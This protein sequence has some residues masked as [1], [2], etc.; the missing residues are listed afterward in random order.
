MFS[1]KKSI[2][3]VMLV[4][5]YLTFN[6]SDHTNAPQDRTPK[7][8]KGVQKE[9][10][11][12]DN[13]FGFK[14]FEKIVAVEQDKNVFISPLSVSMALGM[15]L[16]GANGTTREAM[17]ETLE[18][19]GLTQEEINNSYKNLMEFLYSLDPDVQFQLAN[20]IWYRLGY[21]FE[22]DFIDLNVNYF[23]AEVA[24]LDFSAADAATTMNQWVEAHTNGRIKDMIQ[25]PINPYTIMF[26]INAIYFKGMW[27]YQ[28][29]PKYTKEDV[30]I[31]PDG[32][33]TA[34]QMMAQR[35]RYRYMSN[36]DFQAIDLPYG[37]GDFCM[38]IFLPQHINAFVADFNQENYD[39]WITSFSAD[40]VTLFVPKF[41]LDYEIEL[42]DVLTAL[43]MGIA[44]SDRADFTK[45]YA[46]GN[47]YISKVKHK[48]FLEVNE[49][50]TEA[51]AAT[52]VEMTLTSAPEDPIIVMDVNR[53]FVFVIR[54]TKS[55][56]ILFVG[57]IV[58]PS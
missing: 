28:F 34:C 12:A 38:T 56:S 16:N 24:G 31:L 23:D 8:L 29:D 7:E 19:A 36:D 27:T 53:P 25:P 2:S 40:S 33:R 46:P 13:K 14:L 9:L 26:L 45:M 32:A 52:V 11:Q 22:Q 41:S 54:E 35:S 37:N 43:G 44:F 39:Q 42:N 55:Q 1:F 18:L 50:G 4:A 21:T 47:L 30:F 10:I 51:A 48:S 15:T 3:L 20:S 5:T 58:Q 57:K 49:E 6:C 17:E